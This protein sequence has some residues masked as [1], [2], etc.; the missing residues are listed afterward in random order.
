VLVNPQGLEWLRLP[1]CVVRLTDH[2]ITFLVREERMNRLRL[3]MRQLKL[4]LQG[5]PEARHSLALKLSGLVNPSH[6]YGESG[7]TWPVN[8]KDI[9]PPFATTYDRERRLDRLFVLSQLALIT[10]PSHGD[11]CEMG[12]FNGT[13]AFVLLQNNAAAS[14]FGFDSFEGLS[15]PNVMRDGEYWR[16]GDMASGLETASRNLEC[17]GS[18]VTLIKGWIP[19]VLLTAQ[20]PSSLCLAHIDVD[21]YE[22]TLQSLRYC[23]ERS[24][25]ETLI[26]CDDYG[27]ASCP[28]ATSAVD[29]FLQ[30]TGRW[31][32]VHLP[33]GQA[34]LIRRNT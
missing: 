18:R 31:V 2:T 20:G 24:A 17:F 33:T 3:R 28:G 30:E 29:Q 26:V 1:D 19:E 27:F 7:R 4:L 23:D 21:L 15:S 14:F 10:S 11:I 9:F 16:Q 32:S 12:V 13:S 6:F 5:H 22:P 25:D 34:L 8:A